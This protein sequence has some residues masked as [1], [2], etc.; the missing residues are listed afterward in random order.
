MGDGD[1]SRKAEMGRFS[2]HYGIM[3][4]HKAR[5]TTGF[6]AYSGLTLPVGAAEAATFQSRRGKARLAVPNE[7][8]IGAQIDL[9]AINPFRCF[10]F[11]ADA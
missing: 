10:D 9:E 1:V 2:E 3:R 6:T 7:T 11:K 8:G 4:L 5:K